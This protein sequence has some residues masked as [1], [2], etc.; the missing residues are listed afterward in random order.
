MTDKLMVA[1][2]RK[3][4]TVMGPDLRPQDALPPVCRTLLIP[5]VAR[6]RGG[7]CF[8]ALACD[9]PIAE[10][11][12]LRLGTNTR[13]Y[14]QDRATML[15]VLWRTQVIQKAGRAFFADHPDSVGVNLGC[16]LSHHFQWLDRGHNQW[17]DGDLSEV[18]ALRRPLLPNTGP[19]HHQAETDL[20]QPGW[21]HRLGLPCGPAQAPLFVLC[22]GVLM[23][24]QPTQARAVLAEFAENAPPG[25]QMLI[26]T[27]SPVG[28]GL[29]SLHPTV[30]P[31]GAQFLWCPRSPTE[32][33][34][35]HPRLRLHQTR[36]V[37]ECY[38]WLGT[39]TEACWLPWIGTPMYA[40]ATLAV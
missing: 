38:G 9:D 6:A 37:S 32:L 10:N 27:M 7:Q 28:R 22:E 35:P 33:T 5:L 3:Q 13:P 26:D 2:C 25:S 15:N 20:S 21:W 34:A 29:A 8:P 12:L 19:R 16:G 39:L 31:T 14:L 24:L 36:S 30:G 40:M 4:E 17:L 23:Y 11:I 18:M 1:I